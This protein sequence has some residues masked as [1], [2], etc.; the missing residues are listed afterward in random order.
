MKKPI[1]IHNH[2]NNLTFSKED[3][4]VYSRLKEIINV[5]FLFMVLNLQDFTLKEIKTNTVFS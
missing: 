5:E 4:E 3:Y 1:F 2:S